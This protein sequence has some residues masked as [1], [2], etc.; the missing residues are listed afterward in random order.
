MLSLEDWVV[1]NYS[2]PPIYCYNILRVISDHKWQ[3]LLGEGVSA[4]GE[5]GRGGLLAVEAGKPQHLSKKRGE[6]SEENAH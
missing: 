2:P 4:T 5:P 3:N 1:K 6:K